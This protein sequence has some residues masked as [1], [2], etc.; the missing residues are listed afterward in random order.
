MTKRDRQKTPKPGKPPAKKDAG[1]TTPPPASATNPARPAKKGLP[2]STAKPAE[3]PSSTLAG[4]AASKGV[5]SRPVASQPDASQPDASEPVASQSV[6]SQSVT[7]KAA[8]KAETPKAETPKPETPKP[9]MSEARSPDASKPALKKTAATSRKGA[10]PAQS[11]PS[12]P[13]ESKSPSA[14]ALT[15][16]RSPVAAALNGKGAGDRSNAV[17]VA[18]PGKR[19]A[20]GPSNGALP[21]VLVKAPALPVE[22]AAD[23]IE[24]G[25]KRVPSEP[26]ASAEPTLEEAASIAVAS[27]RADSAQA[28]R[29]ARG[30]RNDRA[31]EAAA[32]GSSESLLST[33]YYF[34]QYG[35]HGLRSRS[36]DVDDFGF[37]PH[38]DTKFRPLLEALCKRYFRVELLGAE[39]IP[40]H[41]R[42]L[43]VANRGGALPWDG[44]VLRTAL[45]MQRPPLSPLRWLAEDSV[46]HYPF[47][48]VVMN[49][50]GAVR[51]CPE[52]A[53]RLLAQDRL[54]AVFPEGAQGSRK[55][56]RDRYRLQR[57]GRG[58]YVKLALKLGVPVFPT[59]IIGAEDTN[60][61]LS[62][63]RLLGRLLGGES[64]PI[65]PT[66][67]WFG[68]AGLLPAPVRWR[69]A[70]GPAIDL[71]AYG[72]D[73]A[74][75]A[76]VVHRLNEQ[77]RS[78]L[79]ALVD[80]GKSARGSALFG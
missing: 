32:F 25:D 80:Q 13:P 52:N 74:D 44:L 23:T 53:E 33:D 18:P 46:I 75:D 8:P 49:R 43:L 61:V 60:P 16:R 6:A 73:A 34:R 19:S 26:A 3:A 45:R 21:F 51:A 72:P 37:D 68:L 63:S 15:E 7:S 79:Q 66:F 76:L 71:S 20:H 17:T 67:P 78:S 54:V 39:H 31:R 56:F 30:S 69:I 40:E 70:V 5:A 29:L 62:R 4:P 11:E 12:A 22:D 36:A 55:L 9:G 27:D 24:L 48:G 65:T 14:A 35:A 58:G 10:P 41:G 28:A 2:P 57:F 50:L 64:L 1:T 38:A 42:A 47:M 59:A 77:I